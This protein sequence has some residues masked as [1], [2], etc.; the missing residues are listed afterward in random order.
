M[1]RL[2]FGMAAIAVL[3]SIN[4]LAFMAGP[5]AA[6]SHVVL[7]HPA[8]Q[9]ASPMLRALLD[10]VTGVHP[11]TMPNGDALG[12]NIPSRLLVGPLE[13]TQLPDRVL[14]GV[15]FILTLLLSG[16]WAAFGIRAVRP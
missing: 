10:P 11:L 4:I 1:G 7:V 3:C 14:I 13:P 2:N 16:V 9:G 15:V 8:P 5:S 12:A 6:Q